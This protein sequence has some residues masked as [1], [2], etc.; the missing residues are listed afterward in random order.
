MIFNPEKVIESAK[1]YFSEINYKLVKHILFCALSISLYS[2][3][4]SNATPVP[5]LSKPNTGIEVKSESSPLQIIQNIQKTGIEIGF[6]GNQIPN[7]KIEMI[8]TYPEKYGEFGSEQFLNVSEGEIISVIA[9]Q[10]NVEITLEIFKDTARDP[11]TEILSGSLDMKIR[12][13]FAMLAK[14]PNIVIRPM[15]EMDTVQARYPW[16]GKDPQKFIAVWRHLYEINQSIGGN[17]KF[18]WSPAGEANAMNYFPGDKYVD[19]VGFSL[20]EYPD[21][22]EKAWYGASRDIVSEFSRKMDMMPFGIPI[23]IPEVGISAETP[24]I[25]ANIISKL[26]QIIK[27][28]YDARI[29]SIIFFNSNEKL[30]GYEAVSFELG[31]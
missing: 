24:A 10:R 23:I 19:F 14:Y 20:Y 27:S 25:K 18:L 28:K 1:R 26:F 3:E 4:G 22:I 30:K 7:S 21:E 15:H 31:D 8:F 11:I 17:T 13:Y 16:S 9:E 2:C 12:N 29:K 5:N 6:F